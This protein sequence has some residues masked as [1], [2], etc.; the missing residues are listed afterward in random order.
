MPFVYLSSWY[1]RFHQSNPLLSN[2]HDSSNEIPK[3]KP[4]HDIVTFDS[5]ILSS[6][7]YSSFF[8]SSI[9]GAGGGGACFRILSIS[10]IN[11]HKCRAYVLVQCIM[12][13]IKSTYHLIVRKRLIESNKSATTWRFPPVMTTMV[14]R[15]AN[16][17]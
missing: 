2:H 12:P 17:I 7:S 13:P 4:I 6:L 11:L 3:N 14:A 9:D 8:V 15:V 16:N 10:V 1:P 5:V